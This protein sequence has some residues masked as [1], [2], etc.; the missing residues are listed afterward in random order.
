IDRCIASGLDI[1]GIDMDDDGK[2][3]GNIDLLSDQVI[4][5]VQGFDSPEAVRRHLAFNAQLIRLLN[6]DVLGRVE[7]AKTID[8]DTRNQ[9]ALLLMDRNDIIRQALRNIIT[10]P[11]ID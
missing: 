5:A 8:I 9:V 3:T 1:Y 6:E 4:E 7:G 10:I 11:K 2:V